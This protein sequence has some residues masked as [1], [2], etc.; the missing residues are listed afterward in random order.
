MDRGKRLAENKGSWNGPSR[1]INT[2]P[3]PV[4]CHLLWGL[5]SVGLQWGTTAL[6][7]VGNDLKCVKSLCTY[8]AVSETQHPLQHR[9]V[10]K[11]TGLNGEMSIYLTFNKP[12]IFNLLLRV[13]PPFSRSEGFF[14]CHGYETGPASQPPYM[15]CYSPQLIASDQIIICD[16]LH[17]SHIHLA[18][19][20]CLCL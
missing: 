13:T 9:E 1:D 8:A 20:K 19:H 18:R 14:G 5:R 7:P 3:S 10:C 2:Q 4:R 17:R 12:P 6:R 15:R 16:V 11:S